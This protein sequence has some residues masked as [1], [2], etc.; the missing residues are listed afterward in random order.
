MKSEQYQNAS[1]EA[2]K[3]LITNHIDKYRDSLDD[4]VENY[5]KIHAEDRYGKNPIEKINFEKSN[6]S[7]EYKNTALNLYKDTFPDEPV[8]YVHVL[9]IA[10]E[11]RKKFIAA[12]EFDEKLPF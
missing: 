7:K 12:S 6:I 1:D 8:D 2:K 5:A 10:K 9:A 11:L 3:L 4:I